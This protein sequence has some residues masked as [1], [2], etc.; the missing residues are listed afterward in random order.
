MAGME[1][2]HEGNDGFEAAWQKIEAIPDE[3]LLERGMAPDEFRNLLA[4][5]EGNMLEE[6]VALHPRAH[7]CPIGM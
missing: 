3:L 2:A 6:V 4:P 5:G 7:L 1:T